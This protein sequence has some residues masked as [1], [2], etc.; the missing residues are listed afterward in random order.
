MRPVKIGKRLAVVERLS[1]I[2]LGEF[3]PV[4]THYQGQVHVLRLRK[5][6]RLL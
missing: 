6:E 2:L 1:A 4:A 5:T 3:F